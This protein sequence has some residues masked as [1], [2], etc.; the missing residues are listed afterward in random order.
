M[1]GAALVCAAL[2]LAVE[3]AATALR[4]PISPACP[5]L[6]VHIDV[7]TKAD[8]QKIID[9]I[10]DDIKPYAIMNIALST[11]GYETG[12]FRRNPDAESLC[13]SWLRVCAENRMWAVVQCASGAPSPFKA[14]DPVFEQFYKEFPNFIGWNYAEQFWGFGNKEYGTVTQEERVAHLASLVE[15]GARYGGYVIESFCN[16]YSTDMNLVA[17]MKRWPALAGACEAHPENFII[18][19]KYTSKSGFYEQESTNFGAFLSGYAGTWGIR[20]DECGWNTELENEQTFP[21]AAGIMPVM[22]NLMLTGGTVVDGPELVWQQDYRE[23]KATTAD[24]F[25]VRQWQL[26]PQYDN[27]TLDIFRRVLDGTIRIPDYNEVVDATRIAV[28]NDLTAETDGIRYATPD[29]LYDGLYRME[30]DGTRT[31][32]LTWMK[33]TGRYPVIPVVARL[34]NSYAADNLRTVTYSDLLSGKRWATESDKINEMNAL[35]D[36]EYTGD[37]F[38]ARRGS[39]WLIYNPFKNGSHATGDIPLRYNTAGSVGVDLS[40]YTTAVMNESTGALT[41]YLNNYR[42][43]LTAPRQ[44]IITI[45]GLN[46]RP[47]VE[48]RSSGSH[49]PVSVSAVWTDDGTCRLTIDHNGPVMVWVNDCHGNRPAT[50]APVAAARVEK[51]ERAPV[52]DGTVQ[53]EAE[54]FDYRSVARVS[55]TGMETDRGITGYQAQGFVEMGNKAGAC[56]RKTFSVLRSS[57]TLFTI[58]YMSPAGSKASMSISLDGGA[59]RNITLPSTDGQWKEYPFK[60]TLTAGAH[61]LAIANQTGTGNYYID[62]VTLQ[63]A[64]AA[65]GTAAASRREGTFDLEGRKTDAPVAGGLYIRDGR[66]MI[67]PKKQ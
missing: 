10:P 45:S 51:P 49:E 39:S 33:R 53:Y 17:Q 18:C 52:Y 5:A 54:C 12:V 34:V 35:F 23:V 57:E 61:T 38:A 62:N 44:D 64:D 63:C 9:L 30:G 22:A 25:T 27:I 56:I 47:K 3:A 55:T 28:V 67:I 59:A 37:V 43:D 7:W 8:P 50:A 66:K 14:D 1:L 13:R 19:D 36:S 15:L 26:F 46:G 48:Y 29:W 11:S 42:T 21:V 24:G 20:F 4:R 32:N 40:Q 58:R 31:K 65:A 6:L 16:A 41:F 2:M 60:H